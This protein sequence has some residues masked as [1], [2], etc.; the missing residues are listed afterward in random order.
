MKH[1]ELNVVRK[2]ETKSK[3]LNKFLNVGEKIY[4]LE[5][6]CNISRILFITELVFP[7]YFLVIWDGLFK[8]SIFTGGIT[9]FYVRT[10]TLCNWNV[11]TGT[12]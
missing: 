6:L 8:T 2:V 10:P 3:W 4:R 1:P 11:F 9:C 7:G 12:L 5:M